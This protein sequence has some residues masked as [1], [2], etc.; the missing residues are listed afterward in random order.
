MH[1]NESSSRHDEIVFLNLW[2]LYFSGHLYIKCDITSLILERIDSLVSSIN[3]WSQSLQIN[4]INS[5]NISTVLLLKI[6]TWLQ[7]FVFSANT[8]SV[9][10]TGEHFQEDLSRKVVILNIKDLFISRFKIE[11]FYQYKLYKLSTT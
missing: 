5:N 3:I 7:K 2:L 1:S 6:A 10:V 8:V 9:S 4:F 11:N